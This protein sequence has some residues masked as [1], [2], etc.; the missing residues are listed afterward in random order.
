M[1]DDAEEGFDEAAVAAELVAAAEELGYAV[2]RLRPEPSGE[3][4]AAADPGLVRHLQRLARRALREAKAKAQAQPDPF[5][6][7]D[8]P[9]AGG[10]QENDDDDDEDDEAA[11]TGGSAAPAA[12]KDTVFFRVEGMTCASCVAMLENVVRHLPAVTRVSVSLM[13]EEAEVEYVPHAGTTP[14]AIREAMADLGF[15]VTRLDKAV[16]GQVRGREANV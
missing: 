14:D 9:L 11:A 12:V 10:R 4:A 2:A 5:A 6:T 13:T 8:H 15:T 1:G 7:L 16:Q 3:G